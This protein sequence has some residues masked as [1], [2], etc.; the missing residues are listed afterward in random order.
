M[1]IL[2]ISRRACCMRP[3]AMQW[4]PA[5]RRRP[6]EC[7]Q[8]AWRRH[9]ETGEVDRIDWVC[10]SMG[11]ICDVCPYA[12]GVPTR[13]EQGA[14]H[15][16]SS[17]TKNHTTRALLL[18]QIPGKAL[19]PAGGH[20]RGRRHRRQRAASV[21]QIELARRAM[22]PRVPP[23]RPAPVADPEPPAVPRRLVAKRDERQLM[24]AVAG[25]AAH[26]GRGGGAAVSIARGSCGGFV[27]RSRPAA[28]TR[29]CRDSRNRHQVYRVRRRSIIVGERER[30]ARKAR[31]WCCGRSGAGSAVVAERL[32]TARGRASEHKRA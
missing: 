25:A 14:S 15:A 12:N 29:L 13:G 22:Q 24:P 31:W 4:P 23:A 20:W 30:R 7:T 11:E 9:T 18:A 2:E 17:H 1:K 32:C 21:A 6:H 16:T 8:K 28:C 26:A 27:L 3:T 19:L 5:E 10:A